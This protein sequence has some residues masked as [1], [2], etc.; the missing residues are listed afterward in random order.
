VDFEA[1]DGE[2]VRFF[3]LLVGPRRDSSKLLRL[4]AKACRLLEEEA[5]RQAL[6]SAK[7]A[8]EVV[9]LFKEQELP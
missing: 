2:P 8:Q 7:T 4:L 6:A 9:R 3:L 1:L 5:F